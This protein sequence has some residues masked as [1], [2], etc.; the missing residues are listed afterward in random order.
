LWDDWSKGCASKYSD[1][2]QHKVWQSFDG[3][4][5][6][7]GTVFY[8]A[9]EG[10]WRKARQ[11]T[12]IDEAFTAEALAGM[13]FEPI[14]YVVENFI[15]EGLTLFTGKPKIGK[16]WLLMHAAYS[17]AED[18]YRSALRRWRCPVRR[19]GRQQTALAL[20]YA[21]IVRCRGLAT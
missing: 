7:I 1:H 19:P 6:G 14:N 4:G 17:T 11:R 10:G 15:A 8:Y 3:S 16:S 12:P 5:I 13:S 21:Q 9:K 20:A 18:G 2:D